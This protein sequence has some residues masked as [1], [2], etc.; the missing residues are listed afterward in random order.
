MN[1]DAV[2]DELATALKTIAGLRVPAWGVEKI[3][4]PAAIIPLPERIVYD[5]SYGRGSD[6]FPDLT[7]IVLVGQPDQRSARKA[8]AA[9]AD[10]SGAK[11]V[12]AA[13]E[14]R[15]Y[16][17]CDSV[18]VA[19]AEFDTARYAGGDYLAAIFHLDITGKGA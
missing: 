7:V 14:A 1:L 10:G 9:Y 6:H 11:S 2:A 12:K 4:P 15:T 17:A 19:W 3:T 8:I 18:R 5:A 16:T 13:L